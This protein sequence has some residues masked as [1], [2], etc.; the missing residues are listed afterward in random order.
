[1]PAFVPC[2]ATC[3][4][5]ATLSLAGAI[6]GDIIGEPGNFLA[7]EHIVIFFSS[8]FVKDICSCLDL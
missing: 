8:I 4:G 2:C 7:I 1:M 3:A 5:R 6:G